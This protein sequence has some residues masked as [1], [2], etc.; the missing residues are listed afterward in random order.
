M[1]SIRSVNGGTQMSE[2]ECQCTISSTDG[3]SSFEVDPVIVMPKSQLSVHP[4][5]LKA[6]RA[7][8]SR[9]HD[10][11]LS[12]VSPDDVEMLIGVNVPLTHRHYDLR[13]LPCG[14]TGP[15]GVR[16]PFRW[17]VVG[18]LPAVDQCFEPV[19]G[20]VCVRMHVCKPISEVEELE[21]DLKRFWAVETWN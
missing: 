20:P 2:T 18:H 6:L 17:T 3:L 21:K 10:L 19:V 1:Y 12:D 16:T 13:V 7:T 8:W 9:P 11:P 4:V 14:S 15:I 5:R